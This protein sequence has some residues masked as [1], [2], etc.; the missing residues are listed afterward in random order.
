MTALSF[1]TTR[2]IINRVFTLLKKQREDE[3]S[4]HSH[5]ERKNAEGLS[6]GTREQRKSYQEG[7]F[8]SFKADVLP[9]VY[10]YVHVSD[11]AI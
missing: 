2:I 5:L 4:K 10:W 8:Y 7:E 1:L 6:E 11:T 3:S 9:A